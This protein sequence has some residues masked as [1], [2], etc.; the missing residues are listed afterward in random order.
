M[1]MS[2]TVVMS[3]AVGGASMRNYGLYHMMQDT[4]HVNVTLHCNL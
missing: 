3:H 4:E 1:Q 2:D